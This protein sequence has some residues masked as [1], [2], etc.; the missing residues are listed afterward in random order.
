MKQLS[1]LGA[2]GSIGTQT[3]D[4]VRRNPEEYQV[5]VLTG[6]TNIAL[7]SQQIE[8]FHPKLAVTA[9]ESDAA[10]LGRKYP[11]VQV[12]HGRTG[13][14]EAASYPEVDLVLN[15][16]VGILGLEP[17]HAAVK[18]GKTIALANKES[19]VAGGAWIMSQVQKHGIQLLPVDSEHNAIFQC[20]EGN[21]PEEV[22]RI[23]LTASGGPFR[24]YTLEQLQQV[25]LEQSLSHPN[26]NMGKKITIDSATMMNKG[27]EVIEASR[28][29]GL[30]GSKIQVVIHPQSIIHS[31]VEFQDRAVLAEL[32]EADMRIPISHALA[33]PKRL[34]N[35]FQ[36]LD[37]TRISSLTFEEPDLSVF[38]CLKLAY[39]A[40]DAGDSYPVVLNAANEVLVDLF[41]RGRINFL[42]IQETL[43]RMLSHHQGCKM[44]D[45]ETILEL[46]RI[47]REDVIRWVS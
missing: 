34:R 47:S 18:T 8:T 36:S 43:E 7:L 19:L 29:F 16:L 1:I 37:L 44:E 12:L 38:R 23:L 26:W 25:T 30:P 27:L 3:L 6:G 10:L 21:R 39:D 40:L 22:K 5:L 15:A 45:L 17:T 24:G 11:A 13:L 41:L 28:L 31:M 20:L 42:K 14:L 35:E 9:R 33:Y 4:L 46:D 2:T 32:G